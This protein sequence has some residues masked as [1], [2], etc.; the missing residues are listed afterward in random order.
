M[1]YILSILILIVFTNQMYSFK[2]FELEADSCVVN[3]ATSIAKHQV[4]VVEATN[5]NDG[6][7]VNQY[8]KSVGIRQ[9]NSKVTGD[10]YCAAGVYWSYMT[11]VDSLGLDK[12]YIPIPRSGS[13]QVAYT[14]A[15]Q[16]AKIASKQD[17]TVNDIFIWRKKNS[18]QGHQG[19]IIEVGEKG[20]VYTVEFNTSGNGT[21]DEREGGGVFIK[22]RNYRHPLGR[23]MTRGFVGFKYTDKPVC[24]IDDIIYPKLNYSPIVDIL[25][26]KKK[27]K[28]PNDISMVLYN[29]LSYNI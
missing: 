14:Y 26:E 27:H 7:M 25:I 10:P 12:S 2:R 5:R 3:L 6:Y 1:K 11:A 19:I 24:E 18:W 29:F 13:S 16:K 20:W 23:L 9:G 17:P 8:Q 22:K 4:G 15:E 21:T 28:R